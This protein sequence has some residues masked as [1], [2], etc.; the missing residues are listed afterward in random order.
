AG[1]L[2]MRKNY[3]QMEQKLQISKKKIKRLIISQQDVF[4]AANFAYQL[5]KYKDHDPDYFELDF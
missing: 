3:L 2:V 1:F 5:L 4:A